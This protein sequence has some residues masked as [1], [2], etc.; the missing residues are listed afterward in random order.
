MMNFFLFCGYVFYAYIQAILVVRRLHTRDVAM[1]ILFA[2]MAPV[3]STVLSIGSLIDMIDYMVLR[4]YYFIS[5]FVNM[6]NYLL[7]AKWIPVCCHV[8]S[9]ERRIQSR[10]RRH[11]RGGRRSTD[12]PTKEND[13]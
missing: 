5:W 9:K 11:R 6:T 10:C 13:V 12:N 3:V 2:I 1:V 4:Y 8:P 7:K